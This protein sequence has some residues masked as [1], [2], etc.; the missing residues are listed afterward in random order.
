MVA[1]LGQ[2]SWTTV[3]LAALAVS[4]ALGKA[5]SGDFDWTVVPRHAAFF[6]RAFGET[7][8]LAVAAFGTSFGLG[9][10]LAVGRLAGRPYWRYPALLTIELFRALPLLMV[11]FWFYF[12]FPALVGIHPS[13]Y[14]S[15]ILAL[16]VCNAAYFAEIIAAGIIAIPRGQREAA[17]STGLSFV[18]TIL[19]V[20][21]PQALRHMIPPLL[22]QFVYL[23]KSTSFVY[24]IGVVE[25][26][27]AATIVNNREFRSFEIFTFV[28][29]VYLVC[30]WLLSS[31]SLL[32]ERRLGRATPR[33]Y[34]VG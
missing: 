20:I 26:F 5:A 18:Q 22:G 9:V 1:A 14:V 13:P 16:T 4:L 34:E 7:L 27:R 32:L 33:L 25:F 10:L 3:I 11:V 31:A 28:A 12:M 24:I 29:L 6:L 30:C 15:G 23:F 8:T 21:L 2:S 17:L 19:Y